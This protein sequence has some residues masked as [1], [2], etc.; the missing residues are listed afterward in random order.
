MHMKLIPQDVSSCLKCAMRTDA[1]QAAGRAGSAVKDFGR[2]RGPFT[3]AFAVVDSDNHSI[4]I[5]LLLV[6]EVAYRL[7]GCTV[8]LS[9]TA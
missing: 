4:D 7:A 8:L 6:D 3:A 2:Q 9:N 5:S 1:A